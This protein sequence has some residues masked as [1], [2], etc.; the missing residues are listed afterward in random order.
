MTKMNRD[1]EQRSENDLIFIRHATTSVNKPHDFILHQHTHPEIYIFI[2]GAA[3]FIYEGNTYSLSPYDIMLVPPNTLHHPVPQTYSSYTRYILYPYSKFYDTLNCHEFSDF[4]SSI[5]ASSA[6]IP[7]EKVKETDIINIL[8]KILK[9]SNDLQ[10]LDKPIIN[11]LFYEICYI[12][13]SIP[14]KK[15]YDTQ[16]T[17]VQGI[18]GYIN[19]NYKYIENLSEIS[20]AL[21]YSLSHLCMLFKKSVGITIHDYI[22]SKRLNN[23]DYLYKKGETLTSACMNS[24]FSS[25]NSFAYT[26][27]KKYNKSPKSNYKD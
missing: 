23:V 14:R 2:S 15:S 26:Y 21:N 1:Y 12:L 20:D 10:N 17:I 4:F 19:E 27:K 24:G 3:Q 9:Y 25:Y 5:N 18:I 11:Y 7:G 13:C 16:N 22:I 8:Y 6:K